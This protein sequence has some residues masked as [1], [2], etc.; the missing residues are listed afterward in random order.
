MLRVL[1]LA[2]DFQGCLLKHEWRQVSSRVSGCII[3]TNKNNSL[4]GFQQEAAALKILA[5]RIHFL[6]KPHPSPPVYQND[7]T[8][9]FSKGAKM[10]ADGAT[11]CLLSLA[12][13]NLKTIFPYF[14]FSFNS[15]DAPSMAMGGKS[16][17]KT[18]TVMLRPPPLIT[19]RG[20]I[21][22]G[23]RAFARI[24]PPT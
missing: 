6:F 11:K 17:Y 14:F 4:P 18:M 2:V 19:V 20:S 1:S 8:L 3:E 15:D 13:L 12:C 7:T 23:P 22:H 10:E 24:R 9:L 16:C 21:N 5:I